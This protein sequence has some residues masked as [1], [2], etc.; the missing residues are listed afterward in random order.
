MFFDLGWDGV[1]FYESLEWG[2]GCIVLFDDFGAT[3]TF[4]D[5]FD[6]R[7]EEVEVEVPLGGVEVVEFLGEEWFFESLVTEELPDMGPVF[8]FDVGIVV[9]V[10]GSGSG[11]GHR[12][13][14]FGQVSHQVP[15]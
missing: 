13:F 10:I 1:G 14:S 6:R 5:K 3:P 12:L 2:F 9:F 8:V 4:F 15:I 11:E 7:D